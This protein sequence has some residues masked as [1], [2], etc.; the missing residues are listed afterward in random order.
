M[1]LIRPLAARDSLEALTALLHRSYAAMAQ[2]GIPF[3]AAS[4]SVEDTRRIAACGQCL[5]A[6]WEGAVIG[7]VVLLGPH[8]E[9]FDGWPDADAWFRERDTARAQLLAVDPAHRGHGVGQR[10][11]RAAEAWAFEHGYQRLALEVAESALAL[12][13]LYRRRGYVEVGQAQRADRPYRSLILQKLLDR[14]PL[15]LHLQTLARYHRWATERLLNSVDALPEADYRRD[16]G[17]VF[18]SLHGTLKLLLLAEEQ[19]WASRFTPSELPGVALATE[20]ES[21]RPALRDQLLEAAFVWLPLL[22]VW[23]ES[24]LHETL[25][26]SGPGGQRVE[27][28]FASALAH[29][30]NQGTHHRG[31]LSAVLTALGHPAP[32]LDLLTMLNEEQ[33]AWVA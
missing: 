5:V 14:S 33:P 18:N 29:V 27:L 2:Q 31:Q 19:V 6:E 12:R 26:Y 13:A 28:P 20:T 32:E 1:L 24:R 7:S 3:S 8:E 9:S 21:S 22:E 11:V 4:Q 10:L 25:A 16:A 15:R 30:F 17:L 23:P